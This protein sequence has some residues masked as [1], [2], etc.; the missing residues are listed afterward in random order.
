MIDVQ[1]EEKDGVIQ[2][3]AIHEQ[4]PSSEITSIHFCE[5]YAK[6]ISKLQ[7]I[8]Q[9]LRDFDW[10]GQAP[11]RYQNT[12]FGNLSGRI[13]EGFLISPSQSSHVARLAE[14][15]YTWVKKSDIYQNQVYSVGHA[16]PSS[17]SM[18][19]AMIY[20]LC[21]EIDFVLHGHVPSLWQQSLIATSPEVGY[22]TI[23]MAN[24]I[25]RL[26]DQGM[27]KPYQIFKM[28]G[29]LDGVLLFGN[30][31]Q[32]LIQTVKQSI[33]TIGNGI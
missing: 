22:G 12:G 32:K 21:P 4:W 5:K 26:F 13:S 10:I 19:H 15:A 23:E 7:E 3:Q 30:D 33:H 2:F 28:S 31:I 18:T 17:E 14:D 9:V 29:H 25:K 1:V 8:R 27:L 20:R 16:L 6:E 24:E 11:N